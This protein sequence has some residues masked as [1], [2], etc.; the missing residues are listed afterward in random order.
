MLELFSTHEEAEEFAAMLDEGND[1]PDTEIG[2]AE[3]LD[4]I[5]LFALVDLV[6]TGS[7]SSQ[8]HV[9]ALPTLSETKRRWR[10]SRPPSPWR[11]IRPLSLQPS[12]ALLNVPGVLADC[13]QGAADVFRFH[14]P[15]PKES[16][17]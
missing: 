14:C 13:H 12:Q 7:I 3:G 10:R 15:L 2:R 9:P 1:A 16:T 11:S 17:P 6:E 5:S 8:L 4:L